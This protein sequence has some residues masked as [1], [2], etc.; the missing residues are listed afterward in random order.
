LLDKRRED[1]KTPWGAIQHFQFS[2]F[3]R[4]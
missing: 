3:R 2:V 4:V 1:H